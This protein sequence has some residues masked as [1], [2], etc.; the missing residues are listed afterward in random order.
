MSIFEEFED[1]NGNVDWRAY[2]RDQVNKG[3]QC[4]TCGAMILWSK[5]VPTQCSQCKSMTEQRDELSHDKFLRC[6]RCGYHWDPYESEDYEVLSDEIHVVTCMECN[7]DFEVTTYVSYS[8]TS[9]PRIDNPAKCEVCDAYLNDPKFCANC[10]WT[11]EKPN[12]TAESENRSR[13]E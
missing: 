5:G 10:G 6:P 11:Q 1:E 7:Y 13:N 4:R 2:D 3:K 8:F 12:A 9:P